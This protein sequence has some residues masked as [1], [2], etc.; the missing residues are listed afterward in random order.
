MTIAWSARGPN[1]TSYDPSSVTLR[2]AKIHTSPSTRKT[3]GESNLR[4]SARQSQWESSWLGVEKINEPKPVSS[5]GPISDDGVEPCTHRREVRLARATRAGKAT[6][7]IERPERKTIVHDNQKEVAPPKSAR[8]SQSID[9]YADD[10]QNCKDIE[11]LKS[12]GTRR[13]A[14][15]CPTPRETL[16][17]KVDALRSGGGPCF[18]PK[19]FAP[20]DAIVTGRRI[21]ASSREEP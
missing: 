1:P 8:V 10:A 18:H 7:G 4:L 20:N 11:I 13:S 17:V 6:V 19:S 14:T 12:S 16:R 5:P 15:P 3:G 21:G 2:R 9:S